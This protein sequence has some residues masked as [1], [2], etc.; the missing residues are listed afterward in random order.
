MARDGG[1]PVLCRARMMDLIG[2]D[3]VILVGPF[4]SGY[5]VIAQTPGSFASWKATGLGME[6]HVP[7]TEP[8]ERCT[9][10]TKGFQFCKKPK[11]NKKKPQKTTN[12]G[13][14]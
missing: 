14:L 3:L 7:V 2:F 10:S 6:L 1:S 4:Q 8:W 13:F 5:S 12:S 9:S 11:N